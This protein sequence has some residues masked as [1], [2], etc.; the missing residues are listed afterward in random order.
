MLELPRLVLG[1]D[2]FPNLFERCCIAHSVHGALKRRVVR[3]EALGAFDVQE[4]LDVS[5]AVLGILRIKP[6][7]GNGYFN[8]RI[9]GSV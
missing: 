6:R 5:A 9:L 2:L 1:I 8:A 7:R 4:G 3:F